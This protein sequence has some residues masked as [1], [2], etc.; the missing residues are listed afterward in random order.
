M[1]SRL[2][3]PMEMGK[4]TLET[5]PS[6]RIVVVCAKFLVLAF[7]NQFVLHRGNW[8]RRVLGPIQQ[9]TSCFQQQLS[10]S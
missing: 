9:R 2:K 5:S 8:K 1:S 4:F 10:R 7:S 3:I 6:F